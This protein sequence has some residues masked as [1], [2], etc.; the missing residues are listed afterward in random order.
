MCHQNVAKDETHNYHHTPK[1]PAKL[2]DNFEKN[3]EKK[4]IFF[5]SL[6]GQK[7]GS[8]ILDIFQTSNARNWNVF[9]DSVAKTL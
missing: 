6:L 8:L 1:Q 5:C 4:I 7:C 9:I 3:S 2:N